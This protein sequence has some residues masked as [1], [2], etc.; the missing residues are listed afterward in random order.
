MSNPMPPKA[1]PDIAHLEAVIDQLE[2]EAAPLEHALASIR[3]RIV[4]TTAQLN[5]LRHAHAIAH[6]LDGDA[7]NP[8]AFRELADLGWSYGRGDTKA[9][10]AIQS[11]VEVCFQPVERHGGWGKVDIDDPAKGAY[12]MLEIPCRDRPDPAATTDACLRYTSLVLDA[13][14]SAEF[15]A[16][17]VATTDYCESGVPRLVIDRG[18]GTARVTFARHYRVRTVATGTPAEMVTQDRKSVV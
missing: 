3:R 10:D 5:H 4:T 11:L 12:P 14:P 1:S 6:L 13:F 8:Q 18:L 7:I 16:F 17:D 2:A 15:V 9:G